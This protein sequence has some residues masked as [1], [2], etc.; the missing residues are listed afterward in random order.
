MDRSL[1]KEVPGGLTDAK[2]LFY[3]WNKHRNDKFFFHEVSPGI[4]RIAVAEI[5]PVSPDT[6]YSGL[7][8]MVLRSEKCEKEAG[9]E[10]SN[11]A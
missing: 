6:H 7:A 8:V 2:H 3:F 5:F 10:Q 9:K 11:D 4:Y 1:E